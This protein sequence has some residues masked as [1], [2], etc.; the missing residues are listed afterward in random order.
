MEKCFRDDALLLLGF[1]LTADLLLLVLTPITFAALLDLLMASASDGGGEIKPTSRSTEGARE[2]FF[3]VADVL[4][5][6]E[7]VGG[8]GLKNEKLDPRLGLVLDDGAFVSLT[9]PDDFDIFS[10]SLSLDEGTRADLERDKVAGVL[11]LE[12]V[13]ALSSLDERFFASFGVG[14]AP[15]SPQEVL[16]LRTTR[17]RSFLGAVSG[18]GG[19]VGGFAGPTSTMST[20]SS[21]GSTSCSGSGGGGGG[22]AAAMLLFFAF[23]SF[24]FFFSGVG[25]LGASSMMSTMSSSSGKPPG[26]GVDGA[27]MSMTSGS[28]SGSFF[29]DDLDADFDV[30]L[31]EDD[32]LG[33][34]SIISIAGASAGGSGGGGGGGVACSS[35][36]SSR[37]LRASLSPCSALILSATL[38]LDDF[39]LDLDLDETA[40]DALD[41]RCQML[42]IK[43]EMAK[44]STTGG[45]K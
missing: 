1:S 20:K 44:L 5:D 36:A 24:D 29:L 33:V 34:A 14:A 32:F 3:G 45:Q 11:D 26:T 8:A 15:Q 4:I 6:L 40:A 38:P 18:S 23:L 21:M 41:V 17:A 16:E 22:A 43:R 10:M 31:E 19:G 2:R 7:R 37:L 30:F 39:S 9:D 28:G 27:G 42:N 12:G 25:S 35:C 13:A